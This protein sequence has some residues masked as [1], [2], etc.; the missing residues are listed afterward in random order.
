MRKRRRHHR[1][2]QRIENE[3]AAAKTTA[4][5]NRKKYEEQFKEDVAKE[6]MA[7]QD[8]LQ[9][10]REDKTLGPLDKARMVAL[11]QEAGQK[12]CWPERKVG[13][14]E[15]CGVSPDRAALGPQHSP[16][17]GNA[18]RGIATAVAPCSRSFGLVM[19][20]QMRRVK[21]RASPRAEFDS[22]VQLA[23][24]RQH[25]AAVHV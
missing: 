9:E 21:K 7:F 17:A 24:F 14:A 20:I 10:I 4:A 2:L 23:V 19:F 5:E 22:R 15:G 13:T 11:S 1:T 12:R 8:K 16:I 18:A 6:D 25:L 3:I